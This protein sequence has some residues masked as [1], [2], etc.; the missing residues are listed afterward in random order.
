M[1]LEPFRRA[2]LGDADD[3]TLSAANQLGIVEARQR[4]EDAWSVAVESFTEKDS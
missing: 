1:K 2:G 4:A 3:V